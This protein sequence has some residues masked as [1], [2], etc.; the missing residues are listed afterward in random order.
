M[1]QENS[2]RL[3]V[4][5]GD[6]EVGLVVLRPHVLEHTYGNNAI[7]LLVQVAVVLKPDINIQTQTALLRHLLLFSRNRDA[8]YANAVIFRH[9]PGKTTP[10]T[11]DVQ[12][13]HTGL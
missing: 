2:V 11:A 1:Q 6:L 12:H 9:K 3:Q 13:T 4:T 8:D 7:E 5:I 10:A